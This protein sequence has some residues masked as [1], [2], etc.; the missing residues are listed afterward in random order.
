MSNSSD[1]SSG[2]MPSAAE[3]KAQ[4]KKGLREF[5][6]QPSIKKLA[7]I[8]VP[9]ALAAILFPIFGPAVAGTAASIAIQNGLKLLGISFSAST[10]EKLLKPLEGKKLEETDIQGVLEDT[11]EKLLPE[12]KQVNEEAAKALV[13]VAPEV[14]EAASANPKLEPEWLAESLE[15]NLKDQ[16]WMMARIASQL[17]ELVKLDPAQLEVARQRLLANWTLISQE[18]TAT[19]SSEVTDVTQKAKGKGGQVNQRVAASNEG[20]VSGVNQDVELT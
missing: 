5:F 17:S 20:K 6:Q 11:L 16:G 4:T 8:L 19:R 10:V 12:D 15:V 18:V 3:T 7:G 2:S 14:K 9:G 13:M 1:D